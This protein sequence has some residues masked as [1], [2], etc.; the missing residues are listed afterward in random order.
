MGTGPVQKAQ[1]VK[2]KVIQGFVCLENLHSATGAEM[3]RREDVTLA[4]I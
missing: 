3:E 4:S 2:Q 1:S